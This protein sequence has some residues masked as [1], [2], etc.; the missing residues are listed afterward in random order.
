VAVAFTLV[1]ATAFGQA[2]YAEDFEDLSP[3]P[4][5][6]FGPDELVER[7]WLFSNQSEPLGS[8]GWYPSDGVDAF[9]PHTGNWHLSAD[10]TST[11]PNGFNPRISNW[12]V[13]P[14]IPGQQAGDVVRFFALGSF[15]LREDRLQVRYAPSGGVDTGSGP[16]EVGDFTELLLDINPIPRGE[17]WGEYAVTLPGPGRIAFRYYL[18]G[19]IGAGGQFGGYFGIDTLT[20]GAPPEGPYPIPQ[21]GET[22]VWN[23]SVSPVVLDGN[24][25][26]PAQ[27]TLVI[28]PGV[29]VETAGGDN[30]GTLVVEGTVLVQGTADTR[31]VME[32]QH[33]WPPLLDVRGT[34]D[35]DFVD[36]LGT[37]HPRAGSQTLMSD[38]VVTRGAL[39]NEIILIAE[40]PFVHLERCTFNDYPVILEDCWSI[41]RDVTVNN[42]QTWLVR[43]ISVTENLVVDGRELNVYGD[44]HAQPFY[45]NG[46]TVTNRT[47]DP[48]SGLRPGLV[49]GWS[50]VLIGPDVTL[51]GN[52]FPVLTY[53]GVLPGSSFNHSGNTYEMI[54][55]IPHDL[56]PRPYWADL[57]VP[58]A[59]LGRDRSGILTIEPGVTVKMD[60]EP[61]FRGGMICEGTPDRPIVFESLNPAI[62]WRGAVDY[63]FPIGL[64]PA[65]GSRFEHCDF[66]G[67]VEAGAI[68]D[69]GYGVHTQNCVFHDN[70]VGLDFLSGTIA[71]TLFVNNEIALVGDPLE[72]LEPNP[73]AFEGNDV[74]YLATAAP[75][76]THVW[77]GHPTG[78]RAPQNPVGQGDPIEGPEAAFVEIFPFLTERPDF[79][80]TPPVVRLVN[81]ELAMAGG[82][83]DVGYMLKTGTRYIIRWS[84]QDD[85]G[86]TDQRI[87]MNVGGTFDTV[88]AE[89]LPGDVRSFEWTVP[90]V[91]EPF[92][93]SQTVRVEATDAAGQKGWDDMAVLISR[94][95]LSS[96]VVL[97]QTFGGQTFIGGDVLPQLDVVGEVD[98][99]GGLWVALLL[100]A[101]NH[102][103][104][105]YANVQY[106]YADFITPLPVVSTDAA[107]LVVGA[108]IDGSGPTWFF[109]PD[110]FSIRHDPRLG[111]EPP[112]VRL[113]TP[114]AG[115]QF[116]GGGVVPITWEAADA[117]DGLYR[118]DLMVSY[119]GGHTW[120]TLAE[121]LPPEARSYDWRLPASTG[122]ADVRVRV[123][124]RDVRFQN[125][126]SGHDRPF[127]I[128]PGEGK[129]SCAADW[130]ADGALNSNDLFDFLDSFFAAGA[131]FDGDGQTNSN[132]FFAFLA[133]YFQGC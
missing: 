20:V 73:S 26:I 78:P 12:A 46:V 115:Q 29:R 68:A 54:A 121:H 38:C 14:E 25:V 67:T 79:G 28:E 113:V 3:T 60:Y 116:L 39:D 132:D 112:T 36:I 123:I 84:A 85:G 99:F 127:A 108:D 94:I 52:Q 125:S 56:S 16:S 80:D 65:S 131:D 87:V 124:A 7:G 118:F 103:W 9:Q 81:T 55:Y 91:G 106:G 4:P 97:D 34:L 95:G 92:F 70:R 17:T 33:V 83:D 35:A 48:V 66:S 119:D 107:R 53:F 8:T 126:T 57:D 2:S 24:V 133:E 71:K 18:P 100:E 37:I 27:A 32:A 58:Y 69:D 104:D 59:W 23:A 102:Q 11:D 44:T 22:A 98:Y 13:L 62:G 31:V 101:D 41:L 21:A 77:W 82:F 15:Y 42:A 6:A 61:G 86:I 111:L 114:A 5:G 122:I 130:N 110:Y 72:V 64:F 49:T 90:D 50:N 19:G 109:Q 89:D 45:V 40:Q 30:G 120:K 10:F 75:D 93:R 63:A 74:A 47:Q 1:P 128:L 105:A 51:T 76:M 129:P 96:Q 117:D 88:I 43:G